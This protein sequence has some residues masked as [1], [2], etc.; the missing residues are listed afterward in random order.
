M[1]PRILLGLTLASLAGSALAQSLDEQL[2][3]A[4]LRFQTARQNFNTAQQRLDTAQKELTR[5]DQRLTD[6]RLALA[7]SVSD[8]GVNEINA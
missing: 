3:A 6:V 1:I 7:L 8:G 2:L 4:Q 5:A